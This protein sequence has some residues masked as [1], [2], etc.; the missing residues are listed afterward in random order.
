[1][2]STKQTS[3][4]LTL[5]AIYTYCFMSGGIGGETPALQAISA[6]FPEVPFTSI[7]LIATIPA[8]TSIPGNILG[9]VLAGKYI[10]YRTLVLISILLIIISGLLP[11]FVTSSFTLILVTRVFFGIGIGMNG[12][13]NNALIFNLVPEEKTTTVTGINQIIRNVTGMVFMLCG[14]FLAMIAWNYSFLVNLFVVVTLVVCALWLPE[15][16]KRLEVSEETAT[17]ETGAA[18]YPVGAIIFWTII[19]FA[20]TMMFYPSMTNISFVLAE[21]NIDAGIAGTVLTFATL[22]GMAGGAVFSPIFKKIGRQTVSLGLLCYAVSQVLLMT[23]SNVPM[24]IIAE[25]LLGIGMCL[26]FASSYMIIGQLTVPSKTPLA[27]CWLFAGMNT[28]GFVSGYFYAA[29]MGAAGIT[30]LRFQFQFG[31]IVYAAM[32]IILMIFFA[33]K[34]PS[35]AKTAQ[36]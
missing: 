32:L 5:F 8:L 35:A 15:P 10:K 34:K 7:L 36:G 24:F 9:G 23:A 22:G 31:A 18:K 16:Q 12:P 3:M 11:F 21:M 29:V 13:L 25:T 1:M 28:G 27:L 2:S 33:V 6:A 17:T 14:G 26:C 19:S 4:A 30:S 20:V